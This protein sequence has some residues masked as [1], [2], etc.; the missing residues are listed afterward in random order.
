[1]GNICNSFPLLLFY[2]LLHLD[3]PQ[4]IGYFMS[5][6]DS[7]SYDAIGLMKQLSEHTAGA[8][9]NAKEVLGTETPD[10]LLKKRCS[11]NEKEKAESTSNVLVRKHASAFSSN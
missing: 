8:F 11:S 2:L 5:P 3:F 4:D 10:T 7:K 6:G 1:M 9:A